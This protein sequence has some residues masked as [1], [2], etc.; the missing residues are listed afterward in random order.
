MSPR[1]RSRIAPWRTP[2]LLAALVVVVTAFAGAHGD[3]RARTTSARDRLQAELSARA[4]LDMTR[5]VLASEPDVRAA[6]APAHVASTGREPVQLDF[7]A[8]AAAVAQEMLA[9]DAAVSLTVVPVDG[10]VNVN[11]GRF[12]PGRDTKLSTAMQLFALMGG[13][14][15]GSRPEPSDSISRTALVEAVLDWQDPDRAQTVFDPGRGAVIVSGME[16]NETAGAPI[17]RKNAPYDTLE[18]LRLLPGFGPAFYRAVV[19]PDPDDLSTLRAAVY[20]TG[21]V[22]ANRAPPEVLLASACAFTI[23]REQ[24]LCE[25]PLEAAAL[26]QLLQTLRQVATA[27]LFATPDDLLD[28]LTRSERADGLIA[29]VRSLLGEGNPLL[30][31]TPLA[32]TTDERAQLRLNFVTTSATYLIQADGRTGGARARVLAALNLDPSWAPVA[33]STAGEQAWPLGVLHYYRLE[34]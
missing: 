28:L 23:T 31:W 24:P 6:I 17:T 15:P 33:S 19:Q 3:A 16:P 22:H 32:L 9:Q 30:T 12:F 1:L 26:V 8:V 21:A 11:P 4:A 27:P 20:G 29:P 25:R 34:R 2:V 7:T 10:L 14:A 5:L 18:E 13:Y